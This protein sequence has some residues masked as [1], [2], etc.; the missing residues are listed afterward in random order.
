[1]RY[2][3]TPGPTKAEADALVALPKFM[4]RKPIERLINATARMKSD[5][6][7][8]SSGRQIGLTIDVHISDPQNPGDTVSA[9]LIWRGCPIRRI[10]WKV[11]ELFADGTV[12]PGWHEHLWDDELEDR[13]GRPFRPPLDG[14]DHLEGMFICICQH[15]NITLVS[16][17]DRPLRLVTDDDDTT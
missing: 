16:R 11:E 1:V 6:I 15:W 14:W 2:G 8:D 17:Q 4:K 10:D 5:Y 13:I 9:A 12:V 3:I 7:Y